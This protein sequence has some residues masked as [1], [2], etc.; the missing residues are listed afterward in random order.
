MK[1]IFARFVDCLPTVAF[2]FPENEPVLSAPDKAWKAGSAMVLM[3][4]R[5]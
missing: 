4:P 2:P 5:E 3:G 1:N